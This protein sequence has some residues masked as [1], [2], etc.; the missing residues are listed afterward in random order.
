MKEGHPIKV[1]LN[2]GNRVLII[3]PSNADNSVGSSLSLKTS[4]TN[5]FMESEIVDLAVQ[6]IKRN[7]NAQLEEDEEENKRNDQMAKFK[8]ILMDIVD[9]IYEKLENMNDEITIIKSEL[10][11]KWFPPIYMAPLFIFSKKIEIKLHRQLISLRIIRKKLFSL[12]KKM[13]IFN[14]N[15]SN[16][17]Y[18]FF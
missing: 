11:Q 10:Q 5:G 3:Q 4:F 18:K 8:T 17:F 6:V 12:Q 2:D 9:P 13:F 15:K 16:Q 14:H 7:R 1:K